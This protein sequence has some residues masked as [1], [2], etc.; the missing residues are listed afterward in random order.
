MLPVALCSSRE[1]DASFGPENVIV[2]LPADGVYT[3]NIYGFEG[4][5]GSFD[6][7]MG[8][9]LTNV[10]IATADTLEA[11]DEGEGHSFPFTT[12]CV[13][14]TWWASTS[15]RLKSWISPSR[16]ARVMRCS[17]GWALIQNVVSMPPL[18]LKS[19]SCLSKRPATTPS[20]S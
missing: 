5:S 15:N 2:A 4:S 16:C 10:V 3:I 9:P 6:L 8:F 12:L 1:R 14:A 18:T 19:L 17:K 20:A 13:L 7:Q 11:E